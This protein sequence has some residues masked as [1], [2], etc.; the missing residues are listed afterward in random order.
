MLGKFEKRLF[1]SREK[2][3]IGRYKN[4]NIILHWHNECELIQIVKGE[5]EIKIGNDVFNGKSGECF[6]CPCEELHYIMSQSDSLVDVLIFH[7]SI[8]QKITKKYKV[9]TPKLKNYTVITS[10]ILQLRQLF[11]KKPRFYEETVENIAEQILLDIFN[12]NEICETENQKHINKKI[13]DKINSDFATI[14]F[15]EITAYSGYSPSHFSKYFKAL[16]G[17][18]FSDYLNFLKIEHAILLIQSSSDLTITQ[19]AVQCGFGSIRNFN[20]VFKK[21]TGFSPVTLPK[22]FTTNITLGI[23]GS[24]NFN[25]TLENSILL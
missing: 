14:T 6:F 11:S 10:K 24:D 20:R 25:P 5:A 1:E 9:V 22:D 8:L 4:L 19:I 21:L 18:T 13:L 7:N 3:W 15:N 16:T 17:M 23:Y 12:N 2:I